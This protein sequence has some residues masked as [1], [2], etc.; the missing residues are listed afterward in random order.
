MVSDIIWGLVAIYTVA[1]GAWLAYQLFHRKTLDALALK[2]DERLEAHDKR[3]TLVE[4][5]FIGTQQELMVTRDAVVR[6]E[7][8]LGET[9]GP[10]P[11]RRWPGEV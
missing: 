6:I 9:T 3:I 7:N 11:A 10:K 2:N 8:R 5:G 4:K 1:V